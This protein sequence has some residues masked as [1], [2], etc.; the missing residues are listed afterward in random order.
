M[1]KKYALDRAVADPDIREALRDALSEW[2]TKIRARYGQEAEIKKLR[3]Q[4]H[5]VADEE[6]DDD[7]APRGVQVGYLELDDYV[8]D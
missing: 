4:I 3:V 1:A 2:L 6:A 8:D 5:V 7:D